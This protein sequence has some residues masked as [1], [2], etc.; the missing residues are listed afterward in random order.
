MSTEWDVNIDNSCPQHVVVKNRN[1]AAAKSF[2]LPITMVKGIAYQGSCPIER[3]E[4][5][6]RTVKYRPTDIIVATY[7]KCGTT[8]IE[9][10]IL[11]LLNDG[12][13]DKLNAASKNTYVPGSDKTGKVWL[14][15]AV[16]QNDPNVYKSG[17]EFFCVTWPEFDAM[18]DR[19]LIKSHAPIQLLLGEFVWH[20][21]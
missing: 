20:M 21:W 9:Q 1:D 14:E 13:T 18:P 10:V 19:R 11:L 17:P 3:W 4:M 2:S 15:A 5:L 6:N 16:D 7:K 8:W 12:R